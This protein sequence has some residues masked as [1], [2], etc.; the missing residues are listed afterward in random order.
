MPNLYIIAGC[1]GAGK[2]TTSYT[3]LPELLNC[4]EFVNADNIAAGLSPFNPESVAIEAGRL[5]LQR[6]RELLM[7]EVDFALETTLATK[8]YVSFIRDA[9][10]KGYHVTLLYFWLDSPQLAINRVA[11]RVSKGGHNIPSETV[12]RRFYGGIKNLL[13]LYLPICDEWLVF[14]NM[15][16]DPELVA[17]GTAILEKQIINNDIWETIQS[18]GNDTRRT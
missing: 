17:Q 3:V 4:R 14:N 7:K 6:I 9:K 2:T 1:N 5:M 12:I 16:I 15:Q 11:K 10:Q 8:N 18:Q 13:E